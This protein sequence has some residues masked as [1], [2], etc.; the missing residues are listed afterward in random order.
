MNV[1]LAFVELKSFAFL[2]PSKLKENLNTL[3]IYNPYCNSVTMLDRS[4][5]L[6]NRIT[7]MYELFKGGFI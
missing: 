3:N 6:I 2:I 5:V 4:Y 7:A 1:V